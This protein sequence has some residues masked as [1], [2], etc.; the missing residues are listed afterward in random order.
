MDLIYKQ[1]KYLRFL[2]GKLFRRIIKHLYGEASVFEIIRYI[3]NK[4]DN[5]NSIM[6]GEKTIIKIVDDYLDEYT[7][8]NEKSFRN[9]SKY[10]ITLFEKNG[11]SLQKHYED[12]IIKTKN[13]YKGIYLHKC[14]YDESM[15]EFILN[16][17]L[18]KIGHLPVAQNIL[19]A[20]KEISP[21][22][23][24][25]F[26]YRSILCDYNT[27]F[28]VEINDSF[29]DYQQNIMYSYIDTILLYKNKIYNESKK[30]EIDKNKTNEYLKSCIFFVYDE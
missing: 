10:I 24:Q 5:K 3:L 17:F 19:I 12:M 29:S 25:S 14:K 9:I 15:E 30:N 8:Y 20:N 18:E 1:N 23:I 7:F 4:V 22:E 13:K 6:D 26:F 21:E 16:I 2:Y 28:I 11:T 27:L